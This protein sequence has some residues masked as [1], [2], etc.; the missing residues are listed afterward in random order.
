M[1]RI[2]TSILIRN[3]TTSLAVVVLI[4]TSVTLLRELYLANRTAILTHGP[5]LVKH[6]KS[7]TRTSVKIIDKTV[8]TSTPYN[9]LNFL[10]IPMYAEELPVS[11]ILNADT[12]KTLSNTEI[13]IDVIHNDQIPDPSQYTIRVA[14]VPENGAIDVKNSQLVYKSGETFVGTDYMV[15]SACDIHNSCST[16]PVTITVL[17]PTQNS[18]LAFIKRPTFF[19]QV[20]FATTALLAMVVMITAFMIYTFR[21][22]KTEQLD[23][24]SIM[25]L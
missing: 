4:L 19:S 1:K 25:T 10:S 12:A 13:T 6:I 20:E 3:L 17:S 21:V 7:V 9:L 24:R 23:D 14:K 18:S 5:V 11:Q 16:A 2:K 22:Y 8:V 15:Y